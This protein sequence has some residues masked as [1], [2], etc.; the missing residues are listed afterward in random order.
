MWIRC[1]LVQL[2][3]SHQSTRIVPALAWITGW[4]T[5]GGT[6][7]Y[8]VLQALGIIKTTATVSATVGGII[9]A[10]FGTGLTGAS[11]YYFLVGVRMIAMQNKR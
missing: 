6:V 8:G 2:S 5:G 11:V 9:G 3:T 1:Y 4:L 7:I 10:I